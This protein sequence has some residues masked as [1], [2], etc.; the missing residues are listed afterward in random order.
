MVLHMLSTVDN[1]WNPHT[2]FEAWSAWDE[3]HGYYTLSLL[4]RIIK[5]S[6]D[7]SQVDQDAATE[8][9]IDEI[10]DENVSGMFI[11]VPQPQA[12]PVA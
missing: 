12:G 7:L 4:G 1:P 6:N 8:H 9:A 3:A 2:Q 11:K 5:T 10:V